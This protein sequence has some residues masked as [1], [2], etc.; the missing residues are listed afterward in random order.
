MPGVSTGV[1]Y[2]GV[3]MHAPNENIRLEDYFR[4]IEFVVGFIRRWAA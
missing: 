4:G 1:G 3:N 2:H